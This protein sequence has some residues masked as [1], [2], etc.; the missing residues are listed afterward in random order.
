MADTRHLSLEEHGAYLQLI[1]IAWRLPDCALPNDDTRI[2][3]ML[4]I[5]AGRWI[6]LKPT[7]MG[8]WTLSN[9]GWTQGRLSKE[10][11]FVKKKSEQNS[12][13]AKVKWEKQAAEN[14]QIDEC[15]RISE[16]NAPPPS[17]PQDKEEVEEE[18]APPARAKVPAFPVDEAVEHWNA[19]AAQVGWPQVQRMSDS[20]RQAVRNRLRTDG[21]EGWRAAI[22]RARTSPY[23]GQAPP[24][25]TFDW[26]AKPGNF[27]KV[28]E[29]N[30]DRQHTANDRSDPDALGINARASIAVFG[31]PG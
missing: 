15:E 24:W 13:A 20:R 7:V 23:L 25:F 11:A 9:K 17:P 21:L 18:A 27:L 19:V 22:A 28:I 31:A 2:S 26:I 6:K 8:F 5:T 10:R 12:H 4:G 29:G 3:R 14:N 16:R 30:Y 1:M